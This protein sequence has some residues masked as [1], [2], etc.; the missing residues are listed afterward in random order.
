[1]VPQ[2]AD[3]DYTDKALVFAAAQ[4]LNSMGGT[5]PTTMQGNAGFGKL[6][7]MLSPKQL[8]FVRAEHFALRAAPTMYSSI[9]PARSPAM[10]KAPTGAED[11]H[12]RKRGRFADQRLDQQS[13]HQPAAAVL[14]RP[15]ADPPPTPISRGP[16]STT[17]SPASAAPASCRATPASTSCIIAETLSY[18]TGRVH[19]K[20]GGD[21]I[22]AWIY[23][24]YPYLFGGEYYFDN[25]KVNPWTF[26]PMKYG[27]PLTPLRAY[28]HDVPRY[29]MQDFGNCGLASRTRDSMPLSCR[30]PSA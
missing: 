10:P 23:N 3:Y 15:A 29:Y 19:W 2:P 21:F 22:Q 5:Y 17:S 24:Y 26:A 13:R 18:E 16:R 12:D 1:M 9:P 30:T 7:F 25:V 6:D 11:V 28:A 8:A 4:Q 27:E 20:F 14:P